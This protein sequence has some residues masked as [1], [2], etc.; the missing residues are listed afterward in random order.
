MPE[1]VLTE[2]QLVPAL[3]LI[4][5][6]TKCP[7]KA[8]NTS[9]TYQPKKNQDNTYSRTENTYTRNK[10]KSNTKEMYVLTGELEPNTYFSK[11]AATATIETLAGC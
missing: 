4:Y 7:L 2:K 1:A 10:K 11:L 3:H 9:Y 8:H 6:N 5:Q